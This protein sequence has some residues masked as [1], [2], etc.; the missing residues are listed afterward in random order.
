M[1]WLSSTRRESSCIYEEAGIVSHW[2][3]AIPSRLSKPQRKAARSSAT[4]IKRND[5]Q[6]HLSPLLLSTHSFL[7]IK[8]SLCL[9]FRHPICYYE[10]WVMSANGL[11]KTRLSDPTA[12]GPTRL[13][14]CSMWLPWSGPDEPLNLAWRSH[15]RSDSRTTSQGTMDAYHNSFSFDPPERNLF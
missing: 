9:H 3:L 13:S 12:P 10:C 11:S 6:F 1:Q 7:I 2:G 4:S 14:P 15:L 8:G 5:E